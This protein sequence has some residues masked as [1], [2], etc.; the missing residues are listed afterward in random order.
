M[1]HGISWSEHA[2]DVAAGFLVEDARGLQQLLDVVDLLADAP[3]PADSV[4]YGSPELRRLRAG[5][6]RVLY[7]IDEDDRTVTVIHVGRLA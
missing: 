5:R 1:S 7:E 6:Y 3:R 2:L 4:P